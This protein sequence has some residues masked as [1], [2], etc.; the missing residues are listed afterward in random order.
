M[1]NNRVY[2]YVKTIMPVIRLPNAAVS[3]LLVSYYIAQKENLFSNEVVE[4]GLH[5]LIR[6]TIILKPLALLSLLIVNPN[7]ILLRRCRLQRKRLLNNPRDRLVVLEEY[8][9]ASGV[10]SIASENRAPIKFIISPS[11]N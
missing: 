9:A 10:P 11:P 1:F 3:Q 2:T 8:L 5:P 4:R 6:I 7:I